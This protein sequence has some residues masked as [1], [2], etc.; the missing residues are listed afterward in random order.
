MPRTAVTDKYEVEDQTFVVAE[1]SLHGVKFIQRDIAASF[2]APEGAWDAASVDGYISS[3]LNEGWRLFNTH[4]GGRREVELN[5][6]RVPV[7]EIV[8]ILER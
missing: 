6:R 8:Y 1:E 7:F 5:G 4:L 3:L 2:P